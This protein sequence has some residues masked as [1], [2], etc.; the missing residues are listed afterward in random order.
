MLELAVTLVFDVVLVLEEEM[1]DLEV[2]TPPVPVALVTVVPTL[3][4]DVGVAMILVG[5]PLGKGVLT[6]GAGIGAG[7]GG[8]AGTPATGL[9]VIAVGNGAGR[10]SAC[11]FSR[12]LSSMAGILVPGRRLRRYDIE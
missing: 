7:T 6:P 1:V 10:S 4:C 11:R 9:V 2:I 3:G 12:W 8:V 5:V